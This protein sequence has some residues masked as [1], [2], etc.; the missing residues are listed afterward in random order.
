MSTIPFRDK[1]CVPKR[2]YNGQKYT[3]YR[4]YKPFLKTDFKNKCGYSNCVDHW[5]GGTTTFQIDHFLPQSK[6]PNLKTE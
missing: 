6:Y 1:D 3:N 2:N 4:K 5:F